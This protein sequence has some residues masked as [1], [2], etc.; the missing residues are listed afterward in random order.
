MKHRGRFSQQIWVV[1]QNIRTYAEQ[2]SASVHL[3][4]Q[5]MP[6]YFI[7]LL[8]GP[9]VGPSSK[10]H[11]IQSRYKRKT[12]Y[13]RY[14][15]K[16][17]HLKIKLKVGPIKCYPTVAC[18]CM[19]GLCKS[20]HVQLIGVKTSTHATIQTTTISSCSEQFRL[21]MKALLF[22]CC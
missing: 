8:A 9:S 22:S 5:L 6:I 21:H 18:E 4:G 17:D 2:H 10:I 1:V 19:W 3:L 15:H 12:N 16:L 20:V 13:V 14:V 11:W 7:L